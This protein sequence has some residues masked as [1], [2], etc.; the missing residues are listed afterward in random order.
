MKK[1][2]LILLALLSIG[3]ITINSCGVIVAPSSRLL[4]DSHP[5][6]YSNN[7]ESVRYYYYPEHMVYFDLSI[8]KYIYLSDGVWITAAMLPSHFGS[9]NFR[10]SNHV[11]IHNYYGD[12]I[13]K[14][15]LKNR[16]KMNKRGSVIK[17]NK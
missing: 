5:G 15:H 9:L 6:Y 17:R 10:L 8:K 11:G 14:Y 4:M 13:T 16:N 12:N 2:G 7:I 3:S 1:F